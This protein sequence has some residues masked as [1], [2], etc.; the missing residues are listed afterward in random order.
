MVWCTVG[1]CETAR[2]PGDSG[3]R[4]CGRDDARKEHPEQLAEKRKD[5]ES[6]RMPLQKNDKAA[7]EI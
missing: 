1:Q 5:A 2:I 6:E 4:S 3:H 7:L